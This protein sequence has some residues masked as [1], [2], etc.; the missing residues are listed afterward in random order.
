MI[1]QDS[2][3]VE[4]EEIAILRILSDSGGAVGGKVIARRLKDEY[5]IV[6]SERA[7]RYHLGLLDGRGLTLK[8]S[9]RDGRAITRLGSEEL[10]DAMVADK[11]GF[12][13]DKIE[14]L[15]YQTSFDPVKRTGQVPINISF[16]PREKFKPALKAM[17][18]AFKAGLG[19]SNL[20]AVASE[21]EKLGTVMVPPGNIG[22]AT[23]CSIIVNGALLKAGI[24]MDSRFGGTLQLRNRKPW[25]FT[26]IID[27]AGSSLDP[28]EI[29]IS[30]RMTDVSGV[31]K[32]GDGKILANFREIPAMC[33]PVAERV[34]EQLRDAGING[35]LLAGEAGK[36]V[37]EVPV[38][39]NKVGLVLAGGLNPI[40]A[41][42]EAGISVT[43]KA[44][45][46]LVDFKDLKSFWEL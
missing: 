44:M 7:V 18:G 43:N 9:R 35:L 27:Y 20:V 1:G 32:Q 8:I 26:E 11:I 5:D 28:S 24:P 22:L 30:S 21:G 13:S 19:V 46:S 10:G 36:P 42:V 2:R 17:A 12:V 33:L 45:S 4:R 3:Q 31:V 15:A 25:R 16:F 37:C 38:G 40:A 34:F 23:V 6:L 29:F 39:L 41:A 14:F